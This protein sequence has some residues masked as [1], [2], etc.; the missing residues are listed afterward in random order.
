MNLI[1]WNVSELSLFEPDLISVSHSN[2]IFALVQLQRNEFTYVDLVPTY[3]PTHPYLHMYQVPNY[4][5]LP[6]CT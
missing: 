2:L 6:T 4:Q 1:L 5:Y 3:V